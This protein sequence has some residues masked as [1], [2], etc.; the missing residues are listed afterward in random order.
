[1]FCLIFKKSYV[2]IS[3][4]NFELCRAAAEWRIIMKKIFALTLT[5]VIAAVS[6]TGCGGVNS[7]SENKDQINVSKVSGT[8]LS[9]KASEEDS[10]LVLGTAEVTIGDAKVIESNGDNVA[11]VEFQ[12]K[13]NGSEAVPFTALVKADARQAD[14]VLSPTVVD[15]VD[16]VDMLSLSEAV[17]PGH[18]ISV[19]KAYRLK[20]TDDSISVEVTE[21]QTGDTE[22]L[23]LIKHFSFE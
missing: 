11:I 4:V 9:S 22:P 18:Q 16:G 15:N 1:M 20:N 13:N 3:L 14:R 7:N 23:Q 17:E 12:F 10:R 5:A 8:S 19:Q 21:I 2:S 6:L